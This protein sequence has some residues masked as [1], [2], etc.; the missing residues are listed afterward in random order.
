MENIIAAIIGIIGAAATGS[1]G[2]L[3]NK[4]FERKEKW[5]EDGIEPKLDLS[6]VSI[7]NRLAYELYRNYM[8]KNETE[9]I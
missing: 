3:L 6:D 8:N 7:S 5:I 2:Y 9:K 1:L 4:K